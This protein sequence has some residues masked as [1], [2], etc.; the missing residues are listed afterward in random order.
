MPEFSCFTPFGFLEFSGEPSVAEKL[1]DALGIQYDVAFDTTPGLEAS[2]NNEAEKYALAMHLAR[3]QLTTQRAG[4]QRNVANAVDMLPNQEASYLAKPGAN[5]TIYQRQQ[6]LV[7]IRALSLG[8]TQSNIAGVLAA[9]LGSAFLKLRVVAQ[10]EVATDMPTSNFATPGIPP[11]VV[12]LVDPVATTGE[13]LWVTYTGIDPTNPNVGLI[14]GT[15]ITVQG[16]N[17]A[18]AEVVTVAATQVAEL[19]G[20]TSVSQFK[21]TFAF[22][23]DPGA[24][25]TSGPLCRWVSTKAFLYVELS[26]AAVVDPII[27]AQVDVLMGKLTRGVTGWASVGLGFGGAHLSQFQIGIT[28]LGTAVIGSGV[29]P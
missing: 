27:R 16:E 11:V 8:A 22:S 12:Q 5:D 28:P 14:A 29:A 26:A 24:T 18:Q 23:H 15:D 13:P 17:N 4:D 19:P 20:G 10:A 6:R 9:T 25:A 2:E 7:A 1:Y 3:V 21:A